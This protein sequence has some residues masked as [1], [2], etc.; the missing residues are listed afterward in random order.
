MYE[1]MLFILVILLGRH[2]TSLYYNLNFKSRINAHPRQHD[3]SNNIV[4]A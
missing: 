1:C 2:L 4:T 3:H